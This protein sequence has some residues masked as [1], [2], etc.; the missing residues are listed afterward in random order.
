MHDSPARRN[1]S[2]MSKPNGHIVTPLLFIAVA[3]A[4]AVLAN[5]STRAREEATIPKAQ[6]YAVPAVW[7]L[8]TR[9]CD[10]VYVTGDRY[11]DVS[12]AEQRVTLRYR[13]GDTLC[14][15]ISSGNRFISDGM[16]TPTGIYSVQGKSP[17]AVSRQ[18]DDAKL[19]SWI[20]FHGNIG[21]HGLDGNGYY[22]TLGV[23]PSSHGCLRMGRE[24]IRILYKQVRTGTPVIVHN[25]QPA[26]VLAFSD[27]A[28]FDKTRGVQLA[29]RN[30]EQMALLK[31]RLDL[32]YSGKLYTSS[33][34]PVYMDDTTRLRPG[35]YET[36]ELTRVT[37]YHERPVVLPPSM[38]SL[39][40]NDRIVAGGGPIDRVPP[41]EPPA[42]E[43]STATE[44]VRTKT[45]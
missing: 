40:M 36:G 35:G 25:G 27:S 14:Y 6:G 15:P 10:T 39:P 11:L 22:R 17:L 43:E 4:V 45:L 16:A 38:F 33:L 29:S 13:N 28:S 34:P 3:V 41:A 24:D 12:L 31:K 23:R 37:L 5:S 20:G 32:L 2:A 18:F 8:F 19:H 44:P 9:L 1:F 30:R 21:F 7:H 42:E 26:R